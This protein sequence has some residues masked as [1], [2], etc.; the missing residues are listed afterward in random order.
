LLSAIDVVNEAISDAGTIRSSGNEWY[1][2]FGDQSYVLKAFEFA[3]KY[4]T[5]YGETQI[6]LYYN[7]YNTENTSK[8]DG[9][10]SLCTPIYNAGYLDGIGMQE[11]NSLT[12]PSSQAFITSYNK[13]DPICTEM[14][15]TELDVSTNSGTNN[16]SPEVLASQANQYAALFKCFVERSYKSGRGKI[17]NVS[18]DGLNDQYTF[19]TNQ[20]SSLWDI[21][22]KCKPSFYA[23]ESVGIN[24]NSLVKLIADADTLHEMYYSPQ[25]WTNFQLVL[26]SVK[27]VAAKN[28]SSSESASAKLSFANDQL[29]TAI[30]DLTNGLIPFDAISRG[31]ENKAYAFV[32]QGILH[33]NNIQSG[34]NIYVYS[35]A[36]S[37]LKLYSG[38]ANSIS[39]P[40]TVPCIINIRSKN[41]NVV[42]K[43]VMNK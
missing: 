42:L 16:P 9:I 15:I 1:T 34:S 12:S 30:S 29:K 35:F 5:Q 31:S 28:Y 40:Y 39:M 41:E 23:V 19:I 6:K 7:D 10:V 21:N 32:N 3:R 33:I 8:A 26:V 17:I 14:A 36:G 27:N 13:F 11:H 20:S 4:T 18:K 37:L 43:V 25:A 2:T 24:Y 22:N 38:S